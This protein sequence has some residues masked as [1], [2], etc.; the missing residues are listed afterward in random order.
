M[1]VFLVSIASLILLA[2]LM[3]FIPN[4]AELRGAY[5]S[6][7]SL[8]VEGV[9][10]DFRPAPT[11]GPAEESFSVQGVLFSY[12]AL[13]NTPCFHNAPFHG[14]PIR[15]GLDVRIHYYGDCIQRVEVLH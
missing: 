12:N 8:L 11:I 15:E 6:G 2:S 5:V 7:K 4:F 3:V 1:G 14:G 13:D 9:V 10:Q